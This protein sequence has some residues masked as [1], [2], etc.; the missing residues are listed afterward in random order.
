MF[1]T[2]VDNGGC[3]FDGLAQAFN[4][5]QGTQEHTEKALRQICYKYYSAIEQ[6]KEEVVNY[7]EE[8]IKI[9]VTVKLMVLF[10][11]LQRVK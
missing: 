2:A 6:N 1:G 11:I 9:P 5:F 7:I 4:A 10:N 3:F 8:I